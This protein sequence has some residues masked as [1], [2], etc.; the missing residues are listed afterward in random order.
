MCGILGCFP[1]SRLR[2]DYLV[3]RGPDGSGILDL[4]DIALGHTRLS[5]LELTERAA[6]PK[7]S[8]SGNVVLTYNGEIYN[9]RTLGLPEEHS[10]TVAL[11]EWLAREGP[12]FNPAQLDG[13]YAFAAYF[14]EERRLVLSRDP[15]GIKPL[16][17]ALSED[18]AQLAFASE[19]KGF[20]GTDWFSPRPNLDGQVQREF[21]QY[22]Y[23]LPRD[24]TISFRS[25]RSTL[26]LV[27]T[28]LASVYQVCPGQTVTVSL[29]AAPSARWAEVPP[30]SQDV[31]SAL[32]ESVKEQSMSDV[33]VGV[34]LSGGIDSSLVAY[35]YAMNNPAVHGFF[36]AVEYPGCSEEPWAEMA[37][38]ILSK[39]CEFQFHRIP[40]TEEEVRRVLPSVVWHMDEPPIRHPNALGVYLLCEYVRRQTKV[41]VLLTGE[42]ADELFGGYRWQDGKRLKGYERSRRIFDLGGSPIVKGF[43]PAPRAAGARSPGSPLARWLPQALRPVSADVLESQLM[44]DRTFYLPPILAR[45]DRM[46]MAHA[47]EARVPFL[48]NRFL[49]MPC[50]TKPGK[51]ALKE[52]A[53]RIFGKP[54]ARRPKSGFGFPTPWLGSLTAPRESLDWLR[55]K[56]KPATDMQR[57]TLAAIGCWAGY[58]LLDGWRQVNLHG[59]QPARPAGPPCGLAGIDR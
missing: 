25:F 35:H 42:G 26:R 52:F 7:W 36:V 31:F 37:N 21:L 3:H 22:G 19:V 38:E 20:F 34:Q 43:F 1:A 58:Y 8:A 11:V 59:G 23:G 33:E 51:S 48:S 45:Q 2:L 5:I 44:F 39:V 4:P 15:V 28:L 14:V 30:V 54:F 27:P 46:S 10:D 47:I 49:G 41:E 13:M 12:G 16:Y 9:Y 32:T 18:G 56:W 29:D 50:P 57:W 53:A 6:Q 40:A 55:E 17:I 24:V